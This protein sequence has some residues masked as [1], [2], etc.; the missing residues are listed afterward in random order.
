M[1]MILSHAA[2][3]VCV[4]RRIITL[5]DHTTPVPCRPILIDE[6]VFDPSDALWVVSPT[7]AS[8]SVLALRPRERAPSAGDAGAVTLSD[9][10]EEPTA[11][12]PRLGGPASTSACASRR[13]FARTS[14]YSM[15]GPIGRR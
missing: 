8:A 13:A 6:R 2:L 9:A 10:T 15:R 3:P 5:C 14:A 7:R 1:H 12:L 11:P 4:P